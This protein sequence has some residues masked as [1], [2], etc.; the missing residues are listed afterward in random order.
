MLAKY[1]SYAKEYVHPAISEE[2]G[3][4]LCQAYSEMRQLGM[5]TKMIT[6]TPRQ[7]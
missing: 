2:A 5:N 4:R 6:A 3:N 7:L 1:I